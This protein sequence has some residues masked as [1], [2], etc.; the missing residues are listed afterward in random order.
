MSCRSIEGN[1]T[2]GRTQPEGIIAGQ[3]SYREESK[4]TLELIL[5][6]TTAVNHTGAVA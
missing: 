3:K 4:K 6:C 2:V 5:E 1:Y